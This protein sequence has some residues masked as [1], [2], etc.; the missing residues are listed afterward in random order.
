ME[1]QT[2]Q[3][4]AAELAEQAYRNKTFLNIPFYAGTGGDYI[5]HFQEVY[6][7]KKAADPKAAKKKPKSLTPAQFKREEAARVNAEKLLA[8]VPTAAIGSLPM[9]LLPAAR[10][11]VPMDVLPS[12]SRTDALSPDLSY[13][14]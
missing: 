6:A 14:P 2:E 12:A 5:K 11:D 7:S 1:R 9:L 10:I 13:K 8:A 4:E 3:E